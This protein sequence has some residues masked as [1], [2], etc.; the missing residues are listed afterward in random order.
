LLLALLELSKLLL[1]GPA[2][3][4]QLNA[5]KEELQNIHDSRHPWA[6][7]ELALKHR[8][9]NEELAIS[10]ERSWGVEVVA[11]R[12]LFHRR[13]C[14]HED[15]LPV[16][17]APNKHATTPVAFGYVVRTH[18]R[19][20]EQIVLFKLLQEQIEDILVCQDPLDDSPIHH[21]SS[22]FSHLLRGRLHVPPAARTSEIGRAH[23]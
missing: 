3:F 18:V 9:D 2:L 10:Q 11:N 15:A 7:L 23:V 12:E 19:E 6:V 1:N 20:V 8:P 4:G 5:V 17:V 13:I 22:F 21:T 16:A 14:S